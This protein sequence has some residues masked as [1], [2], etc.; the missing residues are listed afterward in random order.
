MDE[1]IL[2]YIAED[3][4][5]NSDEEVLTV[6]DVGANI[7]NFT[8][9]ILNDFPM[10]KVY[11]FEPSKTTYNTLVSN[12][13]GV[14]RVVPV[15]IAL[16]DE[17]KE[18]KFYHSKHSTCSSLKTPWE[19]TD[20]WETVSIKKLDTFCFDNQIEKINILKIDA[21]GSDFEVIKGTERM[22][23]LGKI[24][25]VYVECGFK[26]GNSCHG[27]F[28]KIAEYFRRF[29]YNVAGFTE[30]SNF[31]YNGVYT[32]LFCNTIFAKEKIKQ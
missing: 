25:I 5:S 27:D 13:I 16:S 2:K 17:D 10:A 24:D 6:F 32:L 26:P 22:L 23:L 31:E 30:T 21:E 19:K 11:S 29:K 28:F 20:T 4:F 9:K 1:P 7:G 14:D 3:F 15:N 8:K 12:F 18:G